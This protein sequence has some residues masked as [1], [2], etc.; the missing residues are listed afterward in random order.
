MFEV[1]AGRP[2]EQTQ[3]IEIEGVPLKKWGE[4]VHYVYRAD[5]WQGKGRK[6]T[7]YIHDLGKG[8]KI[9]CGPTIANPQV[10][11]C[12]GGKLTLTERGLV[13]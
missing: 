13:F 3:E 10:F 8:V 1:F 4:S 7:D 11:L 5:K 12:F 6:T 2:A 9:Y